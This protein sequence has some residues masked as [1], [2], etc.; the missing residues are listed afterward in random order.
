[1]AVA[2]VTSLN[3]LSFVIGMY[4]AISLVTD[5]VLFLNASGNLSSRFREVVT[6]RFDSVR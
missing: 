4:F 2:R 3:S 5:L 6:Q 1:M